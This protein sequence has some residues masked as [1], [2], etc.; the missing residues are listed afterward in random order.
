MAAS[1]F[2]RRPDTEAPARQPLVVRSVADKTFKPWQ[3]EVK[4]VEPYHKFQWC[5]SGSA[6]IRMHGQQ[7]EL[8]PN[9]FLHF[10]PHMEHW[11]RAKED[12]WRCC[13][14]T[15]YY[16]IPDELFAAFGLER[17]GIY[18]A[19]ACPIQLFKKIAEAA[20]GID[21]RAERQAGE[22]AYQLLSKAAN[23]IQFS[24]QN[25]LIAEATDYI[26]EHW[27][28]PDFDINQLASHFHM[29]RSQLSRQ[30]TKRIGIAPSSY[31][32]RLRLQHAAR[33]L[34]EAQHSSE[35]ISKTCGFNDASYFARRFR[36]AFGMAPQDYRKMG[37]R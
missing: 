1:Y 11:A 35:S 29:H 21:V 3:Q 7:Y 14:V 37:D 19:E 25:D 4:S 9:Q 12:G 15:F 18:Q 22:L 34:L 2:F 32:T 33:M 10:A 5:V 30:F 17:I 24:D 27:Q 6:E 31:L 16:G 13:W 8:L 36:K 20:M 28:D 26:K 23:S